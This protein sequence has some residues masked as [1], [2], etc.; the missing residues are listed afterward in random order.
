MSAIALRLVENAEIAESGYNISVRSY[1]VQKDKSAISEYIKNIYAET[2]LEIAPTVRKFRTVQSES[3]KS[4][5]G[6]QFCSQAS[7]IL[8]E[9]VHKGFAMSD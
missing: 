3:A 8:S 2:E 7:D 1:V 4:H 9:Y 5:V 6:M